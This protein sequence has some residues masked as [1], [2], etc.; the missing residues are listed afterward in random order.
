M[1]LTLVVNPAIVADYPALG[2]SIGV[3]SFQ[4]ANVTPYAHAFPAA[5]YFI[6]QN[7]GGVLAFTDGPL[8]PA[9]VAA[10]PACTTDANQATLRSRAATALATN[11]TYEAIASPTAA[12]QAAQ[13]KALT[14]QSSGVIRL[15][16]GQFDSVADS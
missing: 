4:P 8:T 12:Q 5:G 1:S 3:T 16:L 9:Q 6:V 14:R 2:V 13:I 7:C 10:I 11:A 15:L